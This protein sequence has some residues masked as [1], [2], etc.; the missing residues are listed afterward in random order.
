MLLARS[1]NVDGNARQESQLA[2]ANRPTHLTGNSENHLRLFN[3]DAA[4]QPAIQTW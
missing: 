1:F 4:R 2:V 3:S